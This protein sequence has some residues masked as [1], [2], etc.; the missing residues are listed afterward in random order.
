MN[1]APSLPF[2]IALIIG[3]VLG[4]FTAIPSVA[5]FTLFVLLIILSIFTLNRRRLRI[6][7]PV[8]AFSLIG[9]LLMQHQ[10]SRYDI[11]LPTSTTS[12]TAILTDQPRSTDYGLACEF[13]ILD[14]EMAGYTTRLTVK[15]DSASLHYREQVFTPVIPQLGGIYHIRCKVKPFDDNTS[16]GLWARSQA[17]LAR[18][19][20]YPQNIYP[21]DATC[22]L[23]LDTRLPLKARLLRNHLLERLLPQSSTSDQES[24]A[25]LAAMAFGDRSLVPPE[26]RKAYSLSGASHLLA[27]SGMHLGILYSILMLVF[28]RSHGE[29]LYRPGRWNNLLSFLPILRQMM[30]VALIWMYV[31]LTGMP[32]SIVRAATMLTIYSVVC[33]A[34]NRQQISLSALLVTVAVMLIINPMMI[35]DIGFQMSILAMTAIILFYPGMH[36]VLFTVG[37][38][39]IFRIKA[40]HK[41]RQGERLY[42]PDAYLENI[43]FMKFFSGIILL[44]LAAQLGTAPLAIY[45]F[46][47]FSTSFLLTNI[48]A[49]PLVTIL[50]YSFFLYIALY[51]L[52]RLGAIIGIITYVASTGSFGLVLDAVLSFCVSIVYTLAHGLNLFMQHIASSNLAITDITINLPQLLILYTAL[53][54]LYI[55]CTH[56]RRIAK[57]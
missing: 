19:Y 24:T 42:Y 37:N 33:M 49:I 29:I 53:A 2:V 23:P 40:A 54:V 52:F 39:L 7:P 9:I 11:P 56:L 43:P 38:N 16:Y 47:M 26:L 55:L 41:A 12:F 10:K 44:S 14:G 3:I 35:W 51:L 17:Y 30:I 48:I 4:Y 31:L 6:Y 8:A 36:E 57:V 27:L 50:L 34:G 5:L 1:K 18:G 46:G 45:H 28:G 15:N 25:I 20:V 21:V 32:S 22:H 13:H